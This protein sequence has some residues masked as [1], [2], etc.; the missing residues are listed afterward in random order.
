MPAR[1]HG[2]PP[3]PPLPMR[4]AV[5]MASL[6]FVSE[7]RHSVAYRV[8][9]TARPTT[10]SLVFECHQVYVYRGRKRIGT[11]GMTGSQKRLDDLLA[12][13]KIPLAKPAS[14]NDCNAPPNTVRRALA[15]LRPKPSMCFTHSDRTPRHKLSASPRETYT[16]GLFPFGTPGEYLCRRQPHGWHPPATPHGITAAAG[17]GAG[18]RGY[19]SRADPIVRGWH[20][21]PPSVSPTVSRVSPR[22]QDTLPCGCTTPER[23]FYG[24]SMPAL[25]TPS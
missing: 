23:E 13:A 6:A 22:S 25:T 12:A 19:C 21:V 7:P 4:F 5:L 2:L 9:P 17:T 8:G 1:P 15:A 3:S 20:G 11:A 10:L 14:S 24:Q 16:S 18:P